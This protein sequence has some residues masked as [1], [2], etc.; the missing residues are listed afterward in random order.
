MTRTLALA[1]LLLA[2]APQA[3]LAQNGVQA[4]TVPLPLQDLPTADSSG[5]RVSRWLGGIREMLGF[6]GGSLDLAR[7]AANEEGGQE[8]FN[9]LMGVA[10]FKLKAIESTI[11]L[12]PAL[13]L[14]F[15][16]SRELSE[17]DR[18][19]MERALERHA[20]RH[21]GPLA[22]IQRMVVAGIMEA[23]EVQGFGVEKVVVTLLPLPYVKFTLSPVDAPLGQDA[24]RLMR[25]IDRLNA[26]LQ[27]VTPRT[28]HEPQ[29]PAQPAQRH[30]LLGG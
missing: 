6:G 23:N 16:Q 29:L 13:S 24:S 11:G 14:E 2:A 28:T 7:R 22:A 1:L 3:A 5:E 12:V 8:D 25:A 21:S 18:E 30:A 15:G 19:Y 20:R 9:W 17:A 4:P 26:R 10:G 27:T